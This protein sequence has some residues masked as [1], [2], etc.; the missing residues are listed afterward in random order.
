MSK[1]LDPALSKKMDN[2]IITLSLAFNQS[3]KNEKPVI[4]HSIEV[5]MKLFDYGYDAD[6]VISGILHDLLED[7]DYSP[8]QLASEYGTEVLNIVQAASFNE[9]ITDRREQNVGMFR[10]CRQYG[11]AALLVK[12]ADLIANMP[13]ITCVDS[14]NIELI[15]ILAAKYANFISFADTIKDEPLFEE[16][17]K[18]MHHYIVTTTPL[19][20]HP[21]MGGEFY[22]RNFTT[23]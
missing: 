22:Q 5:G 10:R 12:C 8:A 19:C 3:G 20:G 4:T 14:D 1:R 23:S 18:T 13:F 9:R 2:A 6:I 16:Y 15:Q 11:K 21:S 17:V 7:T